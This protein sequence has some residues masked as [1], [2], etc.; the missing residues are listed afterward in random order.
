MKKE[1][2]KENPGASEGGNPAPAHKT[3]YNCIKLRPPRAPVGCFF[4]S[5]AKGGTTLGG[6]N[7]GGKKSCPLKKKQKTG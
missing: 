2:T 7:A 5:R 4:V 1:E 6:K 3:G